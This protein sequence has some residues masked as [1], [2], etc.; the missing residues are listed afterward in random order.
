VSHALD[1]RQEAERLQDPSDEGAREPLGM[2]DQSSSVL[3]ALEIFVALQLVV[4]TKLVVA[5]IGQ[6]G[7]PA[8][9]WAFLCLLWYGFGLLYRDSG[10]R[11]GRQPV[12]WAILILLV[13]WLLSYLAMMARVAPAAETATADAALLHF[14]AWTGVALLA[15]DGL[16]SVEQLFKLTRF[17]VATSVIVSVVAMIQFLGQDLVAEVTNLPGFE[18]SGVITSVTSRGAFS[19]VAGT[20]THPI[21]FATTTAMVLPLAL[22]LLPWVRRRRLW[23][24]VTLV[25]AIG[26]PLSLSRSGFVGI[27][28]GLTALFVAWP[29]RRRA[30]VLGAIL[31]LTLVF[32][33]VVPG[34]LGTLGRTFTAGRSDSSIT[35]RTDDYAAVSPLIDESPV[36]GRGVGTFTPPRYRILDNQYLLTF[37]EAGAAGVVALLAFFLIPAVAAREAWSRSTDRRL[38]DL[39]RGLFASVL[40]AMVSA[41]TFDA[42]SFWTFSGMTFLIVGMSGAAWRLQR[43]EMHPGRRLASARS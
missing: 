34:L 36:I 7:S 33:L 22:Q 18:I 11:R 38:H 26:I 15:A 4:P 2:I 20:T 10:L 16:R 31:L 25:I 39:S 3:H 27:A 6:V 5:P 30:R 32:F 43:E 24:V 8:T 21:E 35:G 14:L 17:I 28:V 42:F 37:V 12:R 40:V 41:V 1:A 13:V 29:A 23:Q 19:R 9:L